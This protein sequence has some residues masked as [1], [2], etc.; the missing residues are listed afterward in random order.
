MTGF[1][2][3]G[4]RSGHLAIAKRRAI[5]YLD[6]GDMHNAI[7][8]IANDLNKHPDTRNHA[9]VQPLY[10]LA[11]SHADAALIRAAIEALV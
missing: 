6:A 5:E 2:K 1:A 7:S 3:D 10:G 11:L 4:S 8:S 9:G